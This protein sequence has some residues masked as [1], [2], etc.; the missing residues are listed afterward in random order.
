MKAFYVIIVFV[1]IAIVAISLN[2]QGESTSFYGIAD[3]REITINSESPVEI[4]RIHVMQGQKVSRGDTLVELS[5]PDLAMEI[6][7]NVH[8]LDE[9]KAR[10][11]ARIQQLRSSIRELK[12]QYELNKQLTAELKSIKKDSQNS[13]ANSSANPISL[14]IANLERQLQ[15]EL[16]EN[17][18]AEAQARRIR[19]EL[20]MLSE[21]EKGLVSIAQ[22]DG[23]I[24]S[25]NYKV[26]EKAS[27]FSPILT[28]HPKS[29]SLVRGYIHENV[30]SRIYVGQ[31]IRVN[32]LADKSYSIPGTVV[33]VGAR[34]VEYPVRLRKRQDI[35]IWGREVVIKIQADNSFL[36]GE[37][38]SLNVY[39][40][41]KSWR[42]KFKSRIFGN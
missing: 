19:D 8:M 3:A 39:P 24:G 34:I 20:A 18:L 9:V 13:P 41:K 27:P 7:D 29:P 15:H 38:L 36:L 33:G 32:S 6:S 5:R 30:Y 40:D 26:G 11:A 10:R 21:H 1:F 14:K 28:L 2:Y 31:L 35:Q 4:K 37:K 25:V 22:I 12:A 17:N 23:I 42:D 16:S